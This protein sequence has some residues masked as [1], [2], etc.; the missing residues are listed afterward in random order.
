MG[1]ENASER[2]KLEEKWGHKVLSHGWTAVPN[3]LVRGMSDLGLDPT[4]LVI[5]LYLSVFWWESEKLPYPSIQTMSKEIG[6][7][8]KTIERKLSHM[9]KNGILVRKKTIGGATQYDMTPLLS[10]LPR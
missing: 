9:E 5:L 4:S 8:S 10:L 2:Y 6:V 1:E 3:T 7:S